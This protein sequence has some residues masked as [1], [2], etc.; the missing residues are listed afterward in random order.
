MTH[1]LCFVFLKKERKKKKTVY[2]LK[3]DELALWNFW[4]EMMLFIHL[5]I[6]GIMFRT[7]WPLYI[8]LCSNLHESSVSFLKI[9]N[10]TSTFSISLIRTEKTHLLSLL[11][12]F[13][14]HLV[15]IYPTIPLSFMF[16]FLNTRMNFVVL[17][18]YFL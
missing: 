7:T 15:H 11:Y 14:P 3:T 8:M 17:C 13:F 4:W 12:C 1:V 5:S 6:L 18:V 2:I 9:I 16:L 10:E